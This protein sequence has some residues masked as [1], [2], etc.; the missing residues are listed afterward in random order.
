MELNT[1]IDQVL[2]ED[3][4][5]GDHSTLSSVP[6][7]ATSEAILL[8]K[9]EGMLA[10]TEEARA[11]FHRFDPELTMEVMIQDGTIVKPGDW[12]FEV[13]GSARSLLTAERLVLNIMQR[14]SGVA[15]KTHQ[16]SQMIAHTSATLLDTRKTTPG[17]RSLEKKAV[18]IGGGANHRHGLYDMVMLKDNHLDYAGGVGPALAGTRKYL[19]DNQLDLKIEVEVRDRDELLELLKLVLPDRIMLDNFPPSE[20]IWACELIDGRAETEASGGIT[21]ETIVAVAETGVDFISVGA[22]THSVKSLD[23]SLK[24]KSSLV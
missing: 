12:A 13:S 7:H 24:A 16:L 14:M 1:W 2:A 15:T 8:V 23:L 21:E 22:L 3:I 10:G 17:M 4:G 20:L 18:L 5:D 19:A 9:E 6:E 11:V